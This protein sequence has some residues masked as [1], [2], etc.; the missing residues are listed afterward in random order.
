[1]KHVLIAVPRMIH[2]AVS[3]GEGR[4]SS[5]LRAMTP[6]WRF[7]V[8]TFAEPGAER[9]L[10]AAALDLE[11]R[12]GIK[13]MLVSRTP[14]ASGRSSSLMPRIARSHS[15]PA[16][17]EALDAEVRGG[18]VDLVALEFTQMAQYARALAG[19]VPVVTTE[20]DAGVLSWNRS[21]L[22][23]EGAFGW[24]K[25]LVYLRRELAPC[26]RVVALSAAD[27]DRLGPVVGGGR[28]RVVPS[29]VSLDAFPWRGLEDRDRTAAVFVGHYPHFPNEDAAVFLATEVLPELRRLV[30]AARLTLVG[31]RPTP[32]VKALAADGVSVTGTVPSVAPHL[33]S[34][35]V[36]L[37][38]V[39][40]GRGLKGKILEAFAAGVPVVATRAACEGIPG[41]VDGRTLLLA[42][43]PAEFAAAA[44]R[45]MTD[46]ELAGRLSREAR[47]L[48]ERDFSWDRQADLLD[49]VFREALA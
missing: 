48:V 26:R 37:A 1:M 16:M 15:D 46:D 12:A 42:E 23:D 28:L 10:A 27:A 40:L 32:A 13:T 2:P 35:R 43:A 4:V 47:A 19:R 39:R 29:G 24:L 14:G 31:S 7:T 3:G 6:R 36:F 33:A 25:A 41:A 30:P 44:A 8:A 11:A 9:E 45:L 49:A 21:Y 22:R 5:L 20:H 38:A 18:G 34:A 17:A